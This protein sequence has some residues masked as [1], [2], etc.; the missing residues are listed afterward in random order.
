MCNWSILI[1]Y[2]HSYHVRTKERNI[3]PLWGHESTKCRGRSE[4]PVAAGSGKLANFRP[5]G[6]GSNGLTLE[7]S[8]NLILRCSM[9]HVDML[10][11]HRLKLVLTGTSIPLYRLSVSLFPIAYEVV[12]NNQQTVDYRATNGQLTAN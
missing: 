1:G 8:A 4:Q 7:T 3:L 5:A 2:F 12:L 9:F 6:S 10:R 11:R